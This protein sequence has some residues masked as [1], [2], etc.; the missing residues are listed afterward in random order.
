M[1][2]RWKKMKKIMG[3]LENYLVPIGQSISNQRH[4]KAL[5][6][7]I[8]IAVPLILLGSLFVLIG[9][10]PIAGWSEWLN[11]HG[12]LADLFNKAS[13]ASFGIFGL[14]TAFGV[15]YRLAQSY[16]VDGPTTGV[17]SLS[18]F[19]LMTPDLLA[20][21]AKGI[22]YGFMGGKGI[23]AAIIIAFITTEI[24]KWFIKKDIVIKMPSSVPEV[25]GRSF[26]ALIPGFVI[27]LMWLAIYKGLSLSEFKD[28]H[29]LL[30]VII[31]KP[32]GLIAGTLG[33]TF[34]AVFLNSIFW[35][36][37]VNGGQVVN[38]VMNPIWLDYTNQNLAATQA[39][40]ALPH[41]I[42]QPFID[43]FVYMGGGGATIGLA[44]CLL[45]F[46]KSKEYKLLGKISGIPALFN[47][48]TAILF[49]FPTVLNPIM[50][51]PFILNPIINATITYFAM[52]LGLVAK[53]TGVVLP[54]T[55]PPIFGG[56]LSTGHWSGA[57]L[58]LILVFVSFVI[59]YPFFKAADL[60]KLADEKNKD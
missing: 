27:L 30:G 38:T 37:G 13:N 42:T 7:G 10:F 12:G 18:S 41:I 6:E 43:L 45:F 56:F 21:K 50:I 11:S 59:Y 26:A 2:W 39:A 23:F 1:I 58:Q 19:L 60:R 15:A 31:G 3:F 22:P 32:L 29:A 48:N 53:T 57:L 24:Y 40:T 28:I 8:M 34:V 14:V 49:T 47:I 5:R 20:E 9:S 16:D 51:I 17:I 35:F 4:L 25:V 54:W 36:A 52:S 33:G 55:T 46:S 44:L